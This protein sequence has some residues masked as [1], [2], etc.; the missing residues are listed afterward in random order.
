MPTKL[1]LDVDTGTDD[2][3]ALM[4]AALHPDL[5]LIGATTVK[6]N[7]RVEHCT[8]NTLRVFDN[9]G[10]SVPVYEGV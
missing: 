7:V 2:A 5:E 4:L 1:I 3:V 6:G 9:I 8:E 10:V